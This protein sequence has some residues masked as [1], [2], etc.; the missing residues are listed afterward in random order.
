MPCATVAVRRFLIQGPQLF[1]EYIGHNFV[2]CCVIL[3][4]SVQWDCAVQHRV[5]LVGAGNIS[6]PKPT[7]PAAVLRP[8]LTEPTLC[9]DESLAQLKHPHGVSGPPPHPPP[10]STAKCPPAFRHLR[11]GMLSPIGMD[12]VFLPAGYANISLHTPHPGPCSHHNLTPPGSESFE[13]TVGVCCGTVEGR[14][15]ISEA[16]PSFEELYT[17]Q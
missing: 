10:G 1:H 17:D 16:G 12:D 4:I 6:T 14:S 13:V 9:G 5:Y 11:P 15:C 2:P 7:Y 3:F 8:P